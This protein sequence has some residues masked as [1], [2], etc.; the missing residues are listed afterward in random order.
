MSVP[1]RPSFGPEAR[2]LRSDPAIQSPPGCGAVVPLP[3]KPVR[4][5]RTVGP[6]RGEL[7]TG[8]SPTNRKC[9]VGQ[10]TAGFRPLLPPSVASAWVHPYLESVAQ[11]RWPPDH[12]QRRRMAQYPPFE[13][14]ARAS[15]LG[16]FYPQRPKVVQ[17]R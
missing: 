13:V 7:S 10:R 1:L 4:S 15:G 6:S 16:A 2:T 5:S 12:K 9:F 8:K 3:A 11:R 17:R 14:S